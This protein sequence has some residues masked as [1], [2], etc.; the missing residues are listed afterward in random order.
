MLNIM[1]HYDLSEEGM[2]GLNVHRLVEAIKC[3]YSCT[4]LTVSVLTWSVGFSARTRVADPAFL[5]DLD[6]IK[7][8]STKSYAAKVVAN[9]TD[10]S[11]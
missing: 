3:N 1:E 7:K 10:V 4:M 9:I 2:T 5:D 8:L 6:Y 11:F